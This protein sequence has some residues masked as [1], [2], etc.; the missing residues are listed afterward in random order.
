MNIQDIE[1]RY[2]DELRPKYHIFAQKLAGLLEELLSVE[3][4]SIAQIEYRAKAV[5]SFLRKVGSK[6]YEEPFQQIKDLA[7]LRIITYYNDDTLRVA[8]IIRREFSVDPERSADKREQL[9]ID[10]FGYRSVHLVCS[11]KEP[12]SSLIEWRAFGDFYA[13][14]QIRSV[15][16]HAWAAISHKLDYK[17]ASQAPPELR[18]QLFRLSAL[19]ELADEEFAS[20]RDGTKSFAKQYRADVRRG[21][22]DISLSLT[23]LAEYLDH[24]ASAEEWYQTGLAAGMKKLPQLSYAKNV[25][26]SWLHMDDIDRLLLTSQAAGL[27]SVADFA[28][29]IP[30]LKALAHSH[31][32]RFV[33]LVG[34]HGGNIISDPCD[35]L[36]I[37]IS[38]ARCQHLPLDFDWGGA[39]KVSIFKA[40]R[41]ICGAQVAKNDDSER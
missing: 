32:P 18:R 12:R 26:G 10:S 5:D 40:L 19:L 13:E 11:L 35:I 15:L 27:K 25:L 33:K 24:A 41:D 6:Q 23:A 37:L 8:E 29:L 28:A 22:L 16:Q 31:L 14:I 4:A 30:E 36:T 38:V 34:E 9:D 2:R 17:V 7:G 39:F 21:D 20:L 3:Q 1:T